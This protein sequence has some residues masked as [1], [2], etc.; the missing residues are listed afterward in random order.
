MYILSV[1]RVSRVGSRVV[2][3]LSVGMVPVASVRVARRFCR[4]WVSVRGLRSFGFSFSGSFGAS[5]GQVFCYVGGVAV[6]VL[7]LSSVSAGSAAS[8]AR[9]RVA[10]RG[11]RRRGW[12]AGGPDKKLTLLDAS[13]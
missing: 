7:V 6:A 1:Y 11:C 2:R 8:F 13:R 3:G 12:A 4:L 9:H 10:C 5:G